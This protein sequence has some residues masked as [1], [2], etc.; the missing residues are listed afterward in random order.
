MARVPVT[1]EAGVRTFFCGPES[2]TPDLS[3][4]VGEAPGTRGYFVA[5]GMNS[6]GVLSAGGLGRVVA[7]WIADGKPDVDVTGFDID[8]FRTYQAEES[9]RATRTTEIL[10]TVYAAH[11][12]GKQLYS[13]RGAKLSPVHDRLVANGGYLRE[14]SGWEGA[15]W[16][17]GPGQTPEATPT[18]GRADWFERWEA[19]HRAIRERAGPDGHVVHVEVPR[20]RCRRRARARPRLGRRRRRREPSGSPTPSGS[21]TTASCRPTSP[22]PS[23]PTTTSGWSPPTPPTA[24]CSPGCRATSATRDV[25][26]RRTSPRSGPSSTCRARALATCSP[27]LTDADLSNDAFPFRTARFVDARRGA[28]AAGAHHVRRRA[29]LRAVRPGR[30][31]PHRL[32]RRGRGRRGARSGSRR[33]PAAGWRRAIATSATTSTTPTT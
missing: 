27:R 15:D 17:A 1:L 10:G 30:R 31:R 22:S 33:W 24:T 11:T 3:P 18:W 12:P 4:I 13:A 5:A 21:T 26:G 9:Y 6:V 2:F 16:F 29:R 25:D 19:E 23:S 32:R 28:A 8:R 14:V 20:H 7:Q